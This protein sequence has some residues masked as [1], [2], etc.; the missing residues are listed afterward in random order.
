[1]MHFVEWGLDFLLQAI[2]KAC[3]ASGSDPANPEKF[4]AYT[5]PSPDEVRL[6]FFQNSKCS[7]LEFWISPYV[8][9]FQ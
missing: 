8:S 1:M 6:Y 9:K 5:V 4:L 3:V 7:A 2:M